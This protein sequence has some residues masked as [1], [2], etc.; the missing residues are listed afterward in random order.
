MET[1]SRAIKFCWVEAALQDGNVSFKQQ[2]V[3]QNITR[4]HFCASSCVY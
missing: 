4:Q 2:S 1:F 3:E